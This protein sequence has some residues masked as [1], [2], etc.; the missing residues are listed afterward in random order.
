MT[1][2]IDA[3]IAAFVE[4]EKDEDLY[5]TDKDNP[6]TPFRRCLLIWEKLK[7]FI[8]TLNGTCPHRIRFE[9]E[10]VASSFDA[11]TLTAL[12]RYASKAC[13]AAMEDMR[14]P[15]PEDP[16]DPKYF[17]DSIPTTGGWLD[18]RRL[19]DGKLSFVPLFNTLPAK[20]TAN[21]ILHL[22][23]FSFSIFSGR[24][25]ARALLC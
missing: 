6:I 17:L 20:R 24:F 2:L 14:N 12:Y 16:E 22:Q 3:L 9:S 11:N 23:K 18:D 13:K 10:V 5:V 21:P 4:Q 15:P 1:H 7:S 19:N 8:G 25:G